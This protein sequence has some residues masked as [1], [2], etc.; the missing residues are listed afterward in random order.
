[1]ICPFC[2]LPIETEIGVAFGGKRLHQVCHT[3]MNKELDDAFG[4][5]QDDEQ[6]EGS[7]NELETVT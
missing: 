1:M 2:D 4:P 5:S 7:Y 6:V 3:A